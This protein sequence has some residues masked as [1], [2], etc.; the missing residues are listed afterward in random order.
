LINPESLYE[1]FFEKAKEEDESDSP[2]GTSKIMP[3]VKKNEEKP[4]ADFRVLLQRLW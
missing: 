4:H 3:P 2:D 1:F